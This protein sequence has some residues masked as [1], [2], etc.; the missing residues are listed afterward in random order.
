[1]S[2]RTAVRQDGTRYMGT[3]WKRENEMEL[4]SQKDE[5]E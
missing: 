5:A 2:L 4:F 1:M 3:R